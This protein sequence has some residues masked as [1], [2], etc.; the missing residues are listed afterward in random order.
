MK[1]LS[2]MLAAAFCLLCQAKAGDG[3]TLTPAN[4]T[5]TENFDGMWDATASA[6]TLNMPD[7]WR[8]ERQMGAPR[9]VGS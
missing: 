9:M 1:K 8:I 5:A 3:I 6:A 2:I 7:G 4:N